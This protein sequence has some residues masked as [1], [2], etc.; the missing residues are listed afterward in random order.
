[1][2]AV[3]RQVAPDA[4]RPAGLERALRP[5]AQR[6][7]VRLLLGLPR[8]RGGPVRPAD[9]REP[10]GPWACPRARTA[11]PTTSRTTWPMKAIDWLHRVRAERP[12]SPW[13][14]Y[15][16][17]G[18]S[19]APHHVPREWSDKYKGKFDQGWDVAPR[20]DAW[21]ARRSSASFRRI[22]SCRQN[23]AIPE[24]GLPER[25]GAAAVRASD[26]DVRRL[27]GERGLERRPRARR[28]RGDGRARQHRRDLDLGRQR[29]QH[30]GHPLG[31]VQRADDAERHPAHDRAAD[32]APVQARRSRGLGRRPRWRRT[33]RRPG[34]GRATAPSTG[35]S[36]SPPT[37]AAR[38]IRSSS[39]TRRRSPTRAPC[40][41]TSRT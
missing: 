33:T 7:R 25:D 21:R 18:C 5:L 2:T 26:G 36:R 13:F 31:H 24:V 15:Y 32:G 27:L 16:A 34:R 19:H 37:S 9:H 23:E 17:T 22:P 38:A 30:G 20:G 14:M 41:A 4:G 10:E 28:D 6:A 35:A 11:S 1:M 40:A 8:R 12:G 3:H 29:R 39:A